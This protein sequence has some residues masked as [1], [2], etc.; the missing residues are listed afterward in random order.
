MLDGLRH[1][2]TPVAL[3]VSR[4]TRTLVLSHPDAIDEQ[5]QIPVD[6]D[7]AISVSMWL[8]RPTATLLKPAYP[9]ATITD[10]AFL[11]DARLAL[12]MASPDGSTNQT[13]RVVQEPWINDPAWGTLT[14][15]TTHGSNP[16]AALVSVSPDGHHLA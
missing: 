11:T 10:A 15:F 9:G 3:D 16:R 8:R 7:M 6:A 12:S 2:S 1:G 5:W 13:Q 4:G 14:E